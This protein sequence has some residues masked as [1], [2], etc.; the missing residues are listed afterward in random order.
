L[1]STFAFKF[2]LRRY[3]KAQES[4]LFAAGELLVMAVSTKDMRVCYAGGT[5]LDVL[6]A[7]SE[8]GLPPPSSL[9]PP[10]SALLPP[11]SHTAYTVYLTSASFGLSL[12][13]IEPQGAHMI[14]VDRPLI[15]IVWIH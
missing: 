7:G 2:N 12:A 3:N 4:G 11:P 13:F 10:P 15:Q 5:A 14:S 6:G 8:V 1:L 9:L